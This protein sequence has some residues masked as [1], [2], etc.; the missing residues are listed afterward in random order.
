MSAFRPQ[1]SL[2]ACREPWCVWSTRHKACEPLHQPEGAT[3]SLS[4]EESVTWQNFWGDS[5]HLVRAPSRERI[6][7]LHSLLLWDRRGDQDRSPGT[8]PV[9]WFWT[10]SLFRW[11]KSQKGVGGWMIGLT[12]CSFPICPIYF[13]VFNTTILLSFFSFYISFCR[14]KE[15]QIHINLDYAHFTSGGP[16]LCVVSVPLSQARALSI[17]LLTT[18][19]KATSSPMPRHMLASLHLC[20]SSREHFII[21][22][23][24]KKNGAVP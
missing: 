1:L 2:W 19:Q 3:R 13:W 18:G 20:I 11:P 24:H 10:E 7:R 5:W 16:R 21:S 17:F 12:Y 4:L 14:Y 9:C 15:T 23:H 8:S 6:S 22:H